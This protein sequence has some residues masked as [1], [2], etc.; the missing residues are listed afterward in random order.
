[1]IDTEAKL[2]KATELFR[3]Q[4]CPGCKEHLEGV[5]EGPSGGMAVNL[6][7][8]KCGFWWNWG[9]PPVSRVLNLLGN[10]RA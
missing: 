5:I 8:P 7:C 2:D 3:A 6:G 9:M 4:K 1:M 10:R